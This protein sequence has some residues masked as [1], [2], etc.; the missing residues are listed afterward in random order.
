MHVFPQLAAHKQDGDSGILFLPIDWGTRLL[1]IVKQKCA[2]TGSSP[3]NCR[4]VRASHMRPPAAPSSRSLTAL[5][6]IISA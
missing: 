3:T 6:S 5:R 1:Q 2:K 4:A